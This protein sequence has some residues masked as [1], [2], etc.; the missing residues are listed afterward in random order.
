MTMKDDGRKGDLE[1]DDEGAKAFGRILVELE[2]G[3]LHSDVTRELM[4]LSRALREHAKI[5]GKAKGELALTLKMACDEHE[6]MTISSTYKTKLPI[7]PRRQSIM[8]LTRGGNLSPSNPKQVELPLR[9]VEAPKV[10]DAPEAQR[11]R[12]EVP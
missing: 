1:R 4:A 2:D 5:R 6:V 7:P 12:K 3:Q 9:A 10:A 11:V 8:W